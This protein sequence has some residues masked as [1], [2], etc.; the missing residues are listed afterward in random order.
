MS[1]KENNKDNKLRLYA[2]LALTEVPLSQQ[3]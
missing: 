1:Q 2:K 3:K